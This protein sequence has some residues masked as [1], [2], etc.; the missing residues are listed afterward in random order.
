MPDLEIIGAPVSNYVRSCRM[1]CNEKGVEHT[2]TPARPHSPEVAAIHPYGLIPVMRH[3]DLALF[4]SK[5][6]MS[7]VDAAFPGPKMMP[8]SLAEM[9]LV[10]QWVAFQNHRVDRSM[11]RECVVQYVFADKAKGPD[12][13]RIE[14][15]VPD[16]EKQAKVLDAAIAR[17]GHL[18]GKSI[19]MADINVLPMLHYVRMFPEGKAALAG[20]PRLTEYIDRLS[21][22]PSFTATE[23]PRAS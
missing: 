6:I 4:E 14:A 16:I 11:V 1:L 15:A 9:A 2:L 7:Y 3:G 12:R 13:A 19:T 20:L 18:V 21:A 8:E 23:P 10:E 5:A 17:T 22:R